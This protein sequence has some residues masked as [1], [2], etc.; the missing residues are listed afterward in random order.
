MRYPKGQDLQSLSTRDYQVLIIV[1]GSRGFFDKKLF[2][3]KLLDYIE[4]IE[5]PILFISGGAHSGA[6]DMIIR[7]CKKFKY[8]C[9][10]MEAD[11]DRLG[12]AAGFIRNHE[13]GDVGTHLLAYWDGESRGTKDM[14]DYAQE[15][16]LHTKTVLIKV[17]PNGRQKYPKALP[18]PGLPVRSETGTDD[19]PQP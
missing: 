10:V 18:V 2:H 12:K 3:E 15:K 14:I 11:W 4:D 9:K 6:D 17:D 5:E 13:M 7:W 16:G 19:V 1:A 8:P